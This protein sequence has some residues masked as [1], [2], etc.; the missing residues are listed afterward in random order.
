MQTFQRLGISV[1]KQIRIVGL[2]DLKY[3][4]LLGVPLTTLH[5]PCREIGETAISTML[6]R[7]ANPE[8]SAR[9]ILGPQAGSSALLRISPARRAGLNTSC[10]PC[11]S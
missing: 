5:Q 2:D 3:A 11:P 1:P 8:L 9:D 10:A 7:I 4:G 6:E